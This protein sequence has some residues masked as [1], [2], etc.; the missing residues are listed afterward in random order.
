MSPDLRKVVGLGAGGHAAVLIELLQALGGYEVVE[1]TDAN[2]ALWG[3]DILGVPI[4]GGDDRLPALRASGVS[5]AFVGVGAIKTVAPRRAVFERAVSLGFD[6]ITGVH[7][8][9]YVAP[10]A[11]LGRGTCVLPTAMVGTRVRLG[12]DVTV[13][14]GVLIEHDTEVGDH[15]HLSPGVHLAGGVRIGTGCFV[16]IGASVIQGV[17]I[18]D[19]AIV[20]AGAVVLRDLPAGCT[21]VGIPARPVE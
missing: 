4:R 2:P 6:L 5:G 7:P 8:A 13:Y 14:S 11:S 18:G 20:G 15:T 1:V 16:G 9:A 12:E 19:D 21:A 3:Q 17:R 10:S